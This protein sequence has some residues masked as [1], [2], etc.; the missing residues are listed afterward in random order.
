MI[1]ADGRAGGR[2]NRCIDT[3]APPV[4]NWTFCHFYVDI[5]GANEV[6]HP[7]VETL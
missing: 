7:Q 2:Y 3:H 6:P 1:Y 4:T 5:V